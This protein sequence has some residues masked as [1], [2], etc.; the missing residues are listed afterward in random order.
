MG[1][2]P[3]VF[4]IGPV[5]LTFIKKCSLSVKELFNQYELLPDNISARNRLYEKDFNI[6]KEIVLFEKP[7]FP[8]KKK[9][10]KW[11]VTLLKD[12]YND[13][14]LKV[15]TKYNTVLLITDTYSKGWKAKR[16]GKKTK[17]LIAN[18]AFKAISVPAGEHII[19][20]SFMHKGLK[21]DLLLTF[22]SFL[23]LLIV[24]IIYLLLKFRHYHFHQNF[25]D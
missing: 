11:K 19:E 22:I 17:I 16:N 20:L 10:V 24:F 8:L 12:S 21:K 6:K 13:I 9:T 14:K 1:S 5:D 2:D 3:I 23:K 18:Y 7:K 25:Q 15:T 4:V